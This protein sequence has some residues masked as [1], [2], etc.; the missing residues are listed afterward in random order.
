MEKSYSDD[1]KIKAPRKRTS[2]H[3]WAE[4]IFYFN[5]FK[6]LKAINKKEIPHGSIELL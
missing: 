2:K 1:G 5:V 6:E 4:T 3:L